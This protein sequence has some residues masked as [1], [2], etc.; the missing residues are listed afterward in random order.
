MMWNE[1]YE[2]LLIDSFWAAF[3]F[4]MESELTVFAMLAFGTYP[5]HIILP[6]AFVASMCGLTLNWFAG[7]LAVNIA[8][9]L[10]MGGTSPTFEH[11]CKNARRY[12]KW[13]L[14]INWL[15]PFG[16][17][18]TLMAGIVQIRLPVFLLLTGFSRA[19]FYATAIYLYR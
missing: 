17:P 5:L 11:F 4:S 18:I 6:L 19:A 10:N 12:G 7:W 8:T 14:L 2:M 13:L 3:T 9:S 1:L 15:V 16:N